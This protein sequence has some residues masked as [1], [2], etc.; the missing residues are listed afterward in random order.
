MISNSLGKEDREREGKGS[1]PAPSSFLLLSLFS[2]RGE[3][4]LAER[5][6]GEEEMGRLCDSLD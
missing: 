2:C 3:D 1:F 6:G 5:K 4:L